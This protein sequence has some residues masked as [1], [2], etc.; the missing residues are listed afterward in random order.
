MIRIN[1]PR[2]AAGLALTSAIAGV[3]LA[4][5]SGMPAGAV[6]STGTTATI[7][8]DGR[9]IAKA[10][11]NVQAEPRNAAFRAALGTAY[12]NSGRFASAATTF[13]DAMKLG[14]TS[15]RTVLSLAL[16]QMGQGRMREAA[17]LLNDWEGDIATADLGLALSLAGQPD[18]GI[19]LMSNAIRAGDNTP[20]MRQNLAYAYAL[21]GRWREARLMAAQDVPADKLG[22]RIQQWAELSAPEAWHQRIASMLEVPAGVR[23]QGQPAMLALNN[24]PGIEQ[25]VAEAGAQTHPAAAA[26]GELPPLALQAVAPPAPPP[27]RGPETA[28]LPPLQTA[29]APSA[30]PPVAVAARPAAKPRP[31]ATFEAAFAAPTPAAPKAAPAPRDGAPRASSQAAKVGPASHDTQPAAA[32]ARAAPAAAGSHRVQLGSF[33]T[34]QGARRAWNIYVKQHPELASHQMVISEAVVSGKRF[35]RVAAAGFGPR[36]SSAMCGKVKSRG[37]GCIAYAQGR[38]LPGAVDTPIRMARR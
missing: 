7:K 22:D 15:P 32:V 2:R 25:L 23:D 33:A 14:D 26:H 12:L 34:E 38:P 16:A 9:A 27:Y 8:A 37:H 4:G 35:W 5:C 19:H 30:A 3:L 1:N 20:K 13:D 21:A 11:R 31:S 17:A 18:R 29:A 24:A 6:A 28:E 36:D 10:E